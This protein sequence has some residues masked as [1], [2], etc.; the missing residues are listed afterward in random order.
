MIDFQLDNSQAEA[1]L[2]NVLSS[3]IALVAH[4]T[5]TPGNAAR[6]SKCIERFAQMGLEAVS[7]SAVSPDLRETLIGLHNQS[8]DMGLSLVWDLA[9]PYSAFNPI[10]VEVVRIR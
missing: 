9:V 4:L 3:D 1:A 10:A 7:L 8:T 6:A 2:I 5:I